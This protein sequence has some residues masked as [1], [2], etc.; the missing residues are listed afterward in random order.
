M[1]VEMCPI[2][3]Q[4]SSLFNPFLYSFT[5]LSKTNTVRN[6]A[7]TTNECSKHRAKVS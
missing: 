1:M 2:L 5:N 4:S 7:H 6:S 3:T